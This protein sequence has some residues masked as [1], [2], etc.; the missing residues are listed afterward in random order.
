M[1]LSR[2]TNII[3]SITLA[4]F[5]L[6]YLRTFL[7]PLVFAMA[8]WFVIRKLRNILNSVIR[9]PFWLSSSLAS[10]IILIV[11]YGFI[12]LL[13]FQV[14]AFLRPD[15]LQKYN[16]NFQ[17]IGQTIVDM[18]G[19]QAL[20]NGLS[21]LQDIEFTS[22]IQDMLAVL[23]NILGNSFMV[24]LYLLFLILEEGIFKLKLAGMFKDK[25]KR[26]EAYS[27][28]EQIVKSVESYISLKTVVSIITGVASYLGLLIIG[29]DFALFWALLIFILNYIPTVGSLIGTVFPAIMALIQYQDF[30]VFFTVLVVIGI[31]Q[32]IVGNFLEPKV[33]GDNLNISPLVVILSLTLWGLL[34]GVTGM[35]LSVPIMVVLIIILSKIP[36]TKNIA[37]MMSS[38]GN[39]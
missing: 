2:I 11:L 38:D 9:M 31:I 35:I 30:G 7:I 36:A 5:L 23:T 12:Q 25:E 18:V 28:I 29:I 1:S 16:D 27:T 13:T 20:Q 39:V 15:N 8:I 26:K 37:L 19:D 3:L 24:L 21:Q 22:Y 34:W 4:G 17:K 33:M 14:S 32:L 10:L 6:I